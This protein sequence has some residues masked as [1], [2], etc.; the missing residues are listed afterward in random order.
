MNTSTIVLHIMN[1]KRYSLTS[2]PNKP[3][4]APLNEENKSH[5][6]KPCFGSLFILNSCS[7]ISF[8]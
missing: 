4:E 7:A 6:L 1:E 5:I 8:Q 3:K 2:Y